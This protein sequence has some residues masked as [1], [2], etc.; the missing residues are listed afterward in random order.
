MSDSGATVDTGSAAAGHSLRQKASV[1]AALAF[2][3]AMLLRDVEQPLLDRHAWRQTDTASFAR[4]LAQGE[5]DVLHPRFLAYY[6]DA[7]GMDGAVETEFNLY[8]LLVAGLYRLFGVRDLLARL[9]SALFSLGTGLWVY[10]LGRRFYGHRAGL[11]ALL[12]LG[13]S[14]LYVYYGRNVQ[15]DATALFL[16]VGSLYLFT[17]WLETKRW[18]SFAGAA[19]CVSLSFLS[20]I[21]SLH[22]ALPLVFAALAR[23][24]GRFWRE[25]RLW[26]FAL[27]ALAPSALYYLHA[28]RL[29]QET[30]LTVYGISGGWPGSGK[31]DTL[32]QLGS[33]EFYRVMLARLRGPI[34]GW[35]GSLALALGL[36]LW[37]AR[38]SD[39]LLYVWLASVLLFILAVAQGN[40]Q[41]EYYQLPLVPVGALFIGKAL[42]ALS[43]PG[44]VNLSFRLIRQHGGLVLVALVVLLSFRAAL[45]N[46]APMYAQSTLLLEIADATRQW[47]PEDQPVAILHDWARVPEVFYYAERR[48]WALWLE[49]TAEGDYGR[50]IVAQRV[51]TQDGWRVEEALEEDIER[52]ELLRAQGATRLVVSLERGTSGEF[53]SSRL[54]AQ[55][56]A[57]Y[58]LIASDV[59]WLVF[60]LG[61][62]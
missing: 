10:L 31:F 24:R 44:S 36:M 3:L 2:L 42:S 55:L 7:Y 60:G 33:L 6:P 62:I 48:G 58:R 45:T 51:R 28:H 17:D 39:A 43:A 4:G 15:P 40:R 46:L 14:P 22:I 37:S 13:L 52:F 47:T 59:H 54:G 41:H 61:E 18:P 30:G 49:R 34:L 29:Y 56:T 57:R 11:L 20:K 32:S 12:F 53:L 27:I 9:V 23:Y 16:S 19:V 21:T 26:A 50:L 35:Y 25:G 38:K 5:F 1:V 8:P